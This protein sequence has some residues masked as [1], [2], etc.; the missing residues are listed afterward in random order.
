MKLTSTVGSPGTG[1]RWGSTESSCWGIRRE[2]GGGAADPDP[3]PEPEPE[4]RAWSICGRSDAPTSSSALCASGSGE[5]DEERE[6]VD[7]EE[8]EVEL[9]EEED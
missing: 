9:V 3:E 2:E 8:E 6:V 1:W 5:V 4:G 7:E